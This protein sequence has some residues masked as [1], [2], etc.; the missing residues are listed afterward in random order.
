MRDT[1]QG[2]LQGPYFRALETGFCHA[3]KELPSDRQHVSLN[4]KRDE[5]ICLYFLCAHNWGRT[6]VMVFARSSTSRVHKGISQNHGS[7]T[8]KYSPKTEAIIRTSQLAS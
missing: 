8:L 2:F 5:Q 3:D 6:K 1:Q 7:L 4:E